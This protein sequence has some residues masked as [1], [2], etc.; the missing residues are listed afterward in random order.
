MAGFQTH[1]TVSS[2]LGV[3]YAWVGHD[4]YHLDWPSCAVAGMLCAVNGMMPDLDSDSGVPARETL[5]FASAI[6]PMLL[7]TRLKH[8]GVSVEHMLLYGVP[9]YLLIRFGFGS[10]FRRFTVHRGMFHSIPAMAITF[11]VTYLICDTGLTTVRV[12]K[13]IGSALGFFSHLLLDEIWSIEVSKYGT[14]RLKSSSG[15]ALKFF[16]HDP[17][18]NSMCYGVLLLL[19]LGAMQDT[20]A[21]RTAMERAYAQKLQAPK[22]VLPPGPLARPQVISPTQPPTASNGNWPPPVTQPRRQPVPE[23]E[24]EEPRWIEPDRSPLPQP[25]WPSATIDPNRKTYPTRPRRDSAASPEFEG[26]PR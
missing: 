20:A 19:G 6:L 21:E 25:R 26:L 22:T 3:G 11:L 4:V 23:P 5:S 17:L 1:I 12:F 10:V 18:A 8:S 9:L 24:L 2:V 7:F 13:A 14:P 15:T 16:G